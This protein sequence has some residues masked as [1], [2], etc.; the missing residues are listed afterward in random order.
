ML[1]V[2]AWGRSHGRQALGG[3]NAARKKSF[4]HTREAQGSHNLFD[5]FRSADKQTTPDDRNRRAGI[6]LLVGGTSLPGF[7]NVARLADRALLGVDMPLIL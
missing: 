4:R 2:H 3:R 6:G 7:V 5:V 1:D